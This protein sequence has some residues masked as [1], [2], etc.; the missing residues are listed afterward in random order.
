[1]TCLTEEDLHKA[2]ELD[3][4]LMFQGK[5]LELRVAAEKYSK[6]KDKNDKHH[7]KNY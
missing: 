2:A 3:G 5:P 7:H 1:M 4:V 6:H